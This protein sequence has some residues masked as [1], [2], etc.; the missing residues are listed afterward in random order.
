MFVTF[1]SIIQSSFN[2]FKN[3][4]FNIFF[5]SFFFAILD[6][7]FLNLSLNLRE[8]S[9]INEILENRKNL[10]FILNFIKDLS[11][12][13]K[14]L[15]FKVLLFYFFVMFAI[16]IFFISSVLTFLF[17]INNKNNINSFQT[18][19][20]SFNIFP[21]MFFLLVICNIVIY[22]GFLFFILPG[23]IFMISFLL[24]PVILIN[25]KKEKILKIITQSCKMTFLNFWLIVPILFYWFIVEIF[26]V[27]FLEIFYF[28]PN[29]M[30]SIISFTLN[31][32]L[33]FFVLIYLF[34]F[35]ILVKSN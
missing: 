32:L 15:Y 19:L 28:L 3:K 6:L 24:S 17:E 33:I 5:I 2:F 7:F 23:F 34:R 11:F 25:S 4:L 20:L 18:I 30:I 22:F 13:D 31:N 21:K 1:Y 8:V 9:K 12:E 27:F 16:L 14:I 10:I 29:L 35:Y 26:F